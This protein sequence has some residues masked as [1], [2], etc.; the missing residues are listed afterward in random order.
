VLDSAGAITLQLEYWLKTARWFSFSDL[1]V[2]SF[3]CF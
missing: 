1:G 2:S 3:G